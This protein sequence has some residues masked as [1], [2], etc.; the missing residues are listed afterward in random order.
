MVIT[1][2]KSSVY[3]TVIQ[4][5]WA[6]MQNMYLIKLNEIV[7]ATFGDLWVST[8]FI[9]ISLCVTLQC[10]HPFVHRICKKEVFPQKLLLLPQYLSAN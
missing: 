1:D 8:Y 2:L 9:M 6:I 10:I 4:N 5:D 3:Y 7:F